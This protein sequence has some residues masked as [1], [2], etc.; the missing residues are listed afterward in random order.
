MTSEYSK[1]YLSDKNVDTAS[2]ESKN[3]GFKKKIGFLAE[4]YKDEPVLDIGCGA[5]Y[6][7]FFLKQQGFKDITGVDLDQK[8]IEIARS[9]I[10]ANFIRE[11][12]L[13]YLANNDKQYGVIFLWN[14]LE[15]ISSND[16]ENFLKIAN[17]RLLKDGIVIIRTPNLT[18]IFSSGHFYSDFTHKTAFTEHSIR[19]IAESA[20]FSKVEF[21][22]QFSNQNF[23]GKIKAVINWLLH[24]SALWLRGG[25]KSKVFYRN[26]Y[27]ILHK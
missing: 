18:N 15:H 26:L 16:T 5:G 23:K 19:Q 8:L 11:D 20:G 4:R 12:G 17:Q 6:L 14:I 27:V 13:S 24:K 22:N 25:K 10:D 1:F 7:V 9:N 3:R 2:Y 21:M